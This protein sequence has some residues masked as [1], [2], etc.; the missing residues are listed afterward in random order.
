MYF[1]CGNA[2]WL[3]ERSGSAGTCSPVGLIAE[4]SKGRDHRLKSAN[5]KVSLAISLQKRGDLFI[6]DFYLPCLGLIYFFK[7]RDIR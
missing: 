5:E 6:L 4:L 2:L 3:Q 1:S 7:Q